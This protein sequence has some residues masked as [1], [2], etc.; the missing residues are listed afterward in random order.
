MRRKDRDK[1]EIIKN[2]VI[3]LTREYGF[4]GISMAK[5]AREAGIS[6]ATIYIYYDN[7]SSMIHEIYHELR[8]DMHSFVNRKVKAQMSAKE[9]LKITFKSYYDYIINREDEFYFIKQ[10]SSC[11]CLYDEMRAQRYN[12]EME[13]TLNRFKDEKKIK[14]IDNRILYSMLKAPIERTVEFSHISGF[15]FPE[16]SIDEMFK[17][18]WE[19]ISI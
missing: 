1:L 7:K 11:P 14:D 18:I 4:H 3:R 10:F 16:E 13:E 2:T 15:L 9:I 17:L 12:I 19:A 6:P 5:I 8:T